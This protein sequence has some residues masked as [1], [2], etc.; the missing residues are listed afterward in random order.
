[1]ANGTERAAALAA[2]FKQQS[3]KAL[4]E[5]WTA[6]VN[7]PIPSIAPDFVFT[8]VAQRIDITSLLYAG[9]LPEAFTKI[10]FGDRK[11][12]KS[13]EELAEEFLDENSAEEKKAS[14]QFQIE[15]AQQV[16]REPKLVFAD[17]QDD[18]EVD[19]RK[20]PFSGNLI[21]ALFNYAMGLSP[22]VPVKTL[23]GG[24]TTLRAVEKF[25]DGAPGTPL[26]GPGDVVPNVG[27]VAG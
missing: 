16:C 22:D 20:L 18:T 2:Q 21:I 17:P 19:L 24:A 6:E 27:A 3:Q 13:R 11:E 23:D 26:P 1:M 12:K 25:P 8:F 15:I 10:V 14:L 4:A 7:L 9:E 5:Q